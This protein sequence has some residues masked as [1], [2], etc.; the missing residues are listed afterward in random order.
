MLDDTITATDLID[1]IGA[2]Y[3]RYV[4]AEQADNFSSV[5]G[6][7]FDNTPNAIPNPVPVVI[8]PGTYTDGTGYNSAVNL[9]NRAVIEEDYDDLL[10][11]LLEVTF[12]LGGSEYSY[13][14]DVIAELHN[15]DASTPAA[16][17]VVVDMIRSLED[18]P[19]LDEHRLSDIEAEIIER[20]WD[21]YLVSDTKRELPCD[22][23]DHADYCDD[24]DVADALRDAV[25]EF[26]AYPSIE[27][28]SVYFGRYELK[29]I[30]PAWERR[31]KDLKDLDGN[32][33]T[34]AQD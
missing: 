29:D 15:E 12:A 9:A 18:Y 28:E 31:I 34:P 33:F 24:D 10:V 22:V 26:E 21:D 8:I 13:R 20:A 6:V 27:G 7:Y 2:E 16:G 11:A 4:P 14:L 30:V 23:R 5:R 32:A 1:A 19:V 3:V 17:K 25:S